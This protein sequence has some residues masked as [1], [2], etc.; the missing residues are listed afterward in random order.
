MPFAGNANMTDEELKESAKEAY[1]I[2]RKK[3]LEEEN[4]KKIQSRRLALEHFQQ[5][6]PNIKYLQSKDR[7]LLIGLEFQ[8]FSSPNHIFYLSWNGHAAWDLP[9][10]GK[11]L[12]WY[13]WA[14]EY[15]ERNN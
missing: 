5:I 4:E 11:F 1:K 6:F 9:S 15:A 3:E 14:N 13:E 8:V 12:E 10:L 2:F 7:F